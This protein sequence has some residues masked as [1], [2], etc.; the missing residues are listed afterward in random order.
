MRATLAPSISTKK[1]EIADW[2]VTKAVLKDA[3]SQKVWRPIPSSRRNHMLSWAKGPSRCSTSL[4]CI[5]LRHR[6]YLPIDTNVRWA[7]ESAPRSL[8]SSAI[9]CANITS[10][11]T[12]LPS[13]AKHH[14][15]TRCPV[16]LSSSMLVWV[17]WCIR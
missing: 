9:F 7:T 2:Q 5:G 17:P 13:G 10:P 3:G 12:R 4:E 8:V 15:Q 1:T 16:W 14:L 6:S 11:A